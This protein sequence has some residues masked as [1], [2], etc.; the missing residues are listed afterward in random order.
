MPLG[1]KRYQTMGHDHF[2]TFSCYDREP[3]LQASDARDLFERSMERAR[4]KYLFKVLAY[5]VMP[6]HVH[7]L[8]SEPATEPLSK[9]LQSI[10]LSVSKESPQKPFWQARYHDFNIITQAKRVEKIRYIHRNPVNRGLVFEP[11]DWPHSSFKTY[12]SGEQR[13]LFVSPH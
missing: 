12:L 11:E 4:R 7:L 2:V 5:V 3:Y 13:T 10:K 6:E 9:A 1:L 8:I